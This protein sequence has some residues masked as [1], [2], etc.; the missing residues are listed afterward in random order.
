M[1]QNK[2]KK[3][4]CVAQGERAKIKRS[5]NMNSMRKVKA[6]KRMICWMSVQ[7][8]LQHSWCY[9]AA[10]K[11]GLL[12]CVLGLSDISSTIILQRVMKS[13]WTSG[14]RQ[15][16]GCRAAS[17]SCVHSL[18]KLEY[19]NRSASVWERLSS[20]WTA[21]VSWCDQCLCAASSRQTFNCLSKSI[22][23]FNY[24]LVRNVFA[25]IY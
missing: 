3:A 19:E 10:H 17:Q 12:L 9:S 8:F 18:D 1:E 22:N 21:T 13:C 14:G 7:V 11:S 20:L 2:W 25:Y 6:N 5:E 4:F 23:C 15:V 24:A 16:W